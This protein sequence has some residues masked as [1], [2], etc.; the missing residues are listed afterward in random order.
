[1]KK[2][3]NESKYAYMVLL[4]INHETVTIIPQIY[5]FDELNVS[6]VTFNN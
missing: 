2:D 5:Y 3:R 4:L 1:M 6:G